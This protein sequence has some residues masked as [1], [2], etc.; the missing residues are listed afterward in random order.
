MTVPMRV[1]WYRTRLS[2]VAD[3][4]LTAVAAIGGACAAVFAHGAPTGGVVIDAVLVAATVL[5]CSL[6]AGTAPRA[7][8][9]TLCVVAAFIAFDPILAA[10]GLLGGAVAWLGSVRHPDESAPGAIATALMMNVVLRW[11]VDGFFA[12]ETAVGVAI[13]LIV[14][15]AGWR[16]FEDRTRRLSAIGVA[17]VA[18]AV[19][20]IAGAVG[21]AGRGALRDVNLATTLVEDAAAAAEDGDQVRAAELLRAASA[22][23]EQ[24]HD[25]L[26]GLA[27]NAARVLPVV[28][29]HVVAGTELTAEA[30]DTTAAAAAV[31]EAADPVLL[32]VRNGRIDLDAVA[33]AGSATV[34]LASSLDQARVAIDRVDSGWLVPRISSRLDEAADEFDERSNDLALAGDAV[35]VVPDLLGADGPRRYL[36]LF[37]TPSEARGLGGFV[38]NYAEVVI[39]DGRFRVAALG[40]RADLEAEITRVG[41]VCEPCSERLVRDFGRFGFAIGADSGVAPRV[42]SNLTMSPHFPDVAQ[43]AATLY[44]QS[45]GSAVDGVI[46]LDPYVMESLMAYTGPV[47]LPELG[48]TVQPENAADFILRDQYIIVG[49]DTQ[50]QRIDA[51]DHLAGEVI[52]ALLNGALPDPIDLVRDLG[53]LADERRL[54]AWSAHDD[55]QAVFV[56]AGLGGDLPSPAAGGRFA[57]TVDN[58]SANKIETFLERTVTFEQ[59]DHP[60]G[61]TTTVAVVV[62]RNGAPASGLPRY[63]IGNEVGLP[64]GSS[65]SMVTF[66]VPDDSAEATVEWERENVATERGVLSGWSSQRHF[67]DLAA[68]ESTTYRVDLGVD[69]GTDSDALVAWEQPLSR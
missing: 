59:V 10:V 28:S 6:A 15:V 2:Y 4:G 46:A 31:F 48:V 45:G 25:R 7:V 51:L 29:Q 26:D 65:R 34:N 22:R 1:P 69:V 60:D 18:S 53:P 33:F 68:G 54:V 58:A 49:D 42:W 17:V 21:L 66:Y 67:V 39:E 55:E 5:V 43:A 23:F 27:G 32:R 3:Q 19:L 9:A 24:S 35:D 57:Y 63:V 44:P 12:L 50:D 30:A 16:G 13:S 52:V 56:A 64:D 14:V 62:F 37:T 11:D 36:V 41:A 8:I 47:E 38:G 61:S 40:R 20:L